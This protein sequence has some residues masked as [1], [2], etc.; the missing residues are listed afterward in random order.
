[1]DIDDPTFV[2]K[3]DLF[4]NLGQGLCQEVDFFL[5]F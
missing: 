3:S 1:M 4:I 2:P 5:N